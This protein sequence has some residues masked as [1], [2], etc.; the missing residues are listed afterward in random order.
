MGEQEPQPINDH[1]ASA[2]G[3]AC[4][5]CGSRAGLEQAWTHYGREIVRCRDVLA[6]DRRYRDRNP[7]LAETTTS[8]P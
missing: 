7:D 6:C 2:N 4:F 3:L 1:A 8:S 5:F